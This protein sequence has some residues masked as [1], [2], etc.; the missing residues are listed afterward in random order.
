M[1]PQCQAV[2]VFNVSGGQFSSELQVGP[3]DFLTDPHFYFLLLPKNSPPNKALA[4]QCIPLVLPSGVPSLRQA[5]G[6]T[7]MNAHHYAKGKIRIDRAFQVE[8]YGFCSVIRG[9]WDL[10]ELN[11][12]RLGEERSEEMEA[13]TESLAGGRGTN[14]GRAGLLRQL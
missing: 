14:L 7:D 13:Q 1:A 12:H 8:N 11:S 10:Q 9:S 2:G 3:P 4:Y 6:E 5:S